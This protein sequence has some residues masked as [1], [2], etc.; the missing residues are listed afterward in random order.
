MLVGNKI[1][2]EKREISTEEG[3][4]LAEE[5]RLMFMET[6]ALQ[7]HNVSNAFIDLIHGK[8]N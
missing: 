2:Q 6:S 7:N 5:H 3:K 4:K 8:Q 1:D